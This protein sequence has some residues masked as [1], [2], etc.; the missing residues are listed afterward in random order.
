M[1]GDA[2]TASPNCAT[3]ESSICDFVLPAGIRAAMNIFMF[4][5]IAASDWSSVVPQTGHM[6]SPSSSFWVGCRSLA[7]AGA[8]ATS[9]TASATSSALMPAS[10]PC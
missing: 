3:S 7:S 8:A 9:A 4:C 6:I 2:S 5:A 1:G 10:A